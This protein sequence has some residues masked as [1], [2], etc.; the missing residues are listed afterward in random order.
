[1]Q[2][3]RLLFFGAESQDRRADDHADAPEPAGAAPAE[4]LAH[5]TCFARRHLRAAVLARPRRLEPPLRALLLPELAMERPALGC[6]VDFPVEALVLDRQLFLEPRAHLL[7][8][9][10]E[11]R[12]GRERDV[13]R[14]ARY[15]SA[16]GA[17]H[18]GSLATSRDTRLASRSLACRRRA[19][20]FG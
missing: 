9:R 17:L 11:P 8:Q 16:L 1:G 6:L 3:E 13:H 20:E 7:A 15:L 5:H 12:C 18:H 14:G 4:L 19:Q 10:L 2:E